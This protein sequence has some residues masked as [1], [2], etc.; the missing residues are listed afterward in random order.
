M[1]RHRSELDRT[2]IPARGLSGDGRFELHQ[3]RDGSRRYGTWVLNPFED[4]TQRMFKC[5]MAGRIVAYYVLERHSATSIFWSLLGF[6]PGLAG[7]GLG[8]RSAEAMRL[9]PP[10]RRAAGI[11]QHLLPQYPDLRCSDG[12][13]FSLSGPGHHPALVPVRDAQAVAMTVRIPSNKPCVVGPELSYVGQAIAGGQIGGD[14]P[15]RPLAPPI[16][17]PL[18][19]REAPCRS[20]SILFPPAF[21]GATTALSPGPLRPA[22]SPRSFVCGLK[23]SGCRRPVRRA[24]T[25]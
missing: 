12:A 6:A 4:P 5:L 17:E 2:A 13:G 3:R 11:N 1:G 14:R 20:I 19:R 25:N 21:I 10:R 8:H 23:T 24:R 22:A 7:Q 18:Q 15:S 16:P 9:Q